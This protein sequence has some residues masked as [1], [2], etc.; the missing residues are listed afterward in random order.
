MKESQLPNC[1]QEKKT[2]HHSWECGRHLSVHV[3]SELQLGKG[4]SGVRLSLPQT[5]RNPAIVLLSR[6]FGI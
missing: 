5:H 3:R 6:G 1:F 4:S 2:L